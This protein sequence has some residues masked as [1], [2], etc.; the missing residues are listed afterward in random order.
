MPA[1]ACYWCK[2]RVRVRRLA[3]LLPVALALSVAAIPADA[4]TFN[5]RDD[6]YRALGL[7]R[8]RADHDR[9]TAEWQR[10]RELRA[11]DLLSPA[12]LEERDA[13]RVRARVDLLQQAL[14]ALDAAPHVLIER[15]RK[16]R[17]ADGASE[18]ELVLAGPPDAADGVSG[19]VGT[20]DA[21]LRDELALQDVGRLYVSVKAAPGADGA[22]IATP[23]ERVLPRLVGSARQRVTFRLVRD[24][25][26]VVVSLDHGSRVEERRILLESAGD[27]AGVALDLA[28]PAQEVDLGDQATYDVL[29][30]RTRDDVAAVR[31]AVEGL[32]PVVAAEVRAADSD[33][34][35]S[36]VRFALG[37]RAKRLRVLVTLPRD[38]AGGVRVDSTLGFLVVAEAVRVVDGVEV[39]AGEAARVPGRLTARGVPRAELRLSAGWGESKAGDSVRLAAT[40]RNA[41]TRTLA[42]VRVAA[43]AP[44]GWR[45]EARPSVVAMLVPGAEAPL[46]LVLVPEPSA[47]P[48]DY[49]ARLRLEG[50]AGERPLESEPRVLRLRV[51]PPGRGWSTWVAVAVLALVAAASVR[52]G[53]RLLAR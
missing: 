11:R 7:L 14:A 1:R 5:P 9:A 31:V 35:L 50:G 6:R 27:A 43:E 28:Q 37:E 51:V 42:G 2:V 36:V 15:A 16:R 53:R 45:V 18:I 17:L 39:R 29:L 49:E 30:E 20:L 25:S 33:A 3:L 40:V 44:A 48:G 34:R 10:A 12:E 19:I 38:E 13:A 46:T 8:A 21:S 26:D 47:A 41:G 52:A 32:P 23:Y 4:Q 24:A 22:I